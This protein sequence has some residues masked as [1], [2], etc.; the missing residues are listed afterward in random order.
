MVTVAVSLLV[1]FIAICLLRVPI[2]YALLLAC[3]PFF[4]SNDRLSLELVVQRMYGG[5]DSFVLLAVP[6]FVLAGG[7]MNAAQ[8]T[9]RLLTLAQALVG[10]IR[11]GLGMVNVATSMGFGGVSGSSTADVAGLGS[12]L[13]PQMKRRGYSAGY[14]VGITAASAVIGT[15]IP[16]SIQ[17]IVWGSLTSTS[18][19]AMFLGG[20]IPG[21]LIGG[22]MML[23]AYVEA[24]RH[25]YPSE[26]R[27]AWREVTRAFRDSVLALGMIV[28]VLG[29]I[30]GGYVTA[31]EA[32]VIA[33]LYALLLGL[34]VYRTIRIRD[35]PR[36]FRESA[37][38]T[39]LPLFA[40]AAAAVFA[41][42]LAFYQI[43]FLLEDALAGVPAWGILWV[44]VG[45]FLVLGT[46]LDALPAMAIMIPVLA[47]AVTAAGVHPVQYG[48]VAVIALAFGLITP[49]YGL[50]LLLASKIGRIPVTKA[51]KPMLPFAGVIVVTM[52][53]AILVPDVVLWLPGLGG[54]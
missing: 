41:Y 3:L 53:L 49:P 42:L 1:I 10:W 36:I 17:M 8:V 19:G 4:F 44:V 18:I 33:V 16:P 27:M 30:I 9:D 35:L 54:Q 31:T 50:C 26:R 14:A 22:G 21:I 40:L 24:R 6:F 25:G 45:I 52:V 5:V 43:P 11:G 15:I 13:I 46:F 32:S 29:G 28:I 38:L 39:A 12:I 34:V 2:A 51:I 48:V 47:P 37:L 20:V 7:I 23:V